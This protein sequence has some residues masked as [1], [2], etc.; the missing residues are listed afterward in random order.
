VTL[1]AKEY[2]TPVHATYKVGPKTIDGPFHMAE[3]TV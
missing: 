3:V 1:K 2:P